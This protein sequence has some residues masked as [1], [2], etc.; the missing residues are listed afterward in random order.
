MMEMDKERA[1]KQPPTEQEA[2]QRTKD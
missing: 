2:I 1:S